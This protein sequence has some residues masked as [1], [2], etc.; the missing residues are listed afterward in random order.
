MAL[1]ASPTTVS[2]YLG[3]LFDRNT[4]RGTS[5]RPYVAAIGTQHR[6]FGMDDPTKYPLVV[7][8]RQ[9][10]MANDARRGLGPPLR[11]ALLPAEQAKVALR[12]AL[13]YT[14]RNTLVRWGI[15]AVG[16]LLCARPTSIRSLR[17]CDV[18]FDLNVIKVKITQFKY[19]ERGTSLRIALRIPYQSTRSDPIVDLIRRLCRAAPS[20]TSHLFA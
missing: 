13:S 18:S 20:G 9:D 15:I 5:L 1:P 2:R 8:T 19:G 16:F 6:R 12:R 14:S 4:V 11:S 7:A 3:H 17:R 10:Y